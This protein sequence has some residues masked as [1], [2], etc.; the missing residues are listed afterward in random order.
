MGLSAVNP[1][2]YKDLDKNI[3]LTD[4]RGRRSFFFRDDDWINVLAT[5]SYYS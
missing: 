5:S 1:L 3:G 4:L 2:I